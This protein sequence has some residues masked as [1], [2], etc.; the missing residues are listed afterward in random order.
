MKITPQ[1]SN[2][3]KLIIIT[4]GLVLLAFVS[5]VGYYLWSR[6]E[7][8]SESTNLGPATAQEKA[9]GDAAKKKTIDASS[10]ESDNSS[11][12]KTT[13]D[14]NAQG[15]AV[16]PSTPQAAV[17]IRVTA[18]SQNGNL[19]QLRTQIDGLFSTGLCTLTITKGQQTV[20]KTASIQALAQ[21]S[22]C[23]GFDIATSELS[24]G[25]WNIQLSFTSDQSRGS[26]VD[27]IEVK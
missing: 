9:D 11:S 23:Q 21:T 7:P 19:Y 22:T 12:E 24:P 26:I 3:K 20:T 15:S 4:F 14:T 25:M 17:P 10:S 8:S 27:T 2:K 5:G 16:Q 13:P 1:K 18:K 6:Q